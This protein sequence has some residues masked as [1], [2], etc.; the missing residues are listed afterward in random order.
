MRRLTDNRSLARL[1][2]HLQSS[3]CFNWLTAGATVPL[4]RVWVATEEW[5]VRGGWAPQSVFTALTL[6]LHHPDTR[7]VW[8]IAP[9]S[10]P[11]CAAVALGSKLAGTYCPCTETQ[12]DSIKGQTDGFVLHTAWLYLCVPSASLVCWWVE[13]NVV[14]APQRNE[15]ITCCC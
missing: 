2:Q 9:V 4:R 8:Q 10:P 14:D 15:W 3:L 1:L 7:L 5:R 12:P 13:K 11:Q 6:A